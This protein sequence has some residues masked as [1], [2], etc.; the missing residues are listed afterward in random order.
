MIYGTE[1]ENGLDKAVRLV[2][3]LIMVVFDTIRYLL[4]LIAANMSMK[5]KSGTPI[6]N[7]G[8]IVGLTSVISCFTD[9]INKL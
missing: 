6:V 2:I 8:E 5:Q 7:H 3:M 1:D 4:L 9:T